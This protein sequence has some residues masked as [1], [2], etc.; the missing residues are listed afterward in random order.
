MTISTLFFFYLCEGHFI[1]QCNLQ[2]DLARRFCFSFSFP[3]SHF[4]YRS[5]TAGDLLSGNG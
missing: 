3:Y 4:V 2:A 5:V 1:K